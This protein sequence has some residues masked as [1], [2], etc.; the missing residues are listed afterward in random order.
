MQKN[1]AV[2]WFGS[3]RKLA[4]FLG[5]PQSNVSSWKNVPKHHQKTIE[6]HTKG[7]LLAED[8][9]MKTRYMCTIERMY[10]EMLK[11]HSNYLGVPVVEVLR[12][13]IKLYNKKNTF[14]E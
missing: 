3:Q 11:R 10:V 8:A 13:A 12:R 2:E 9:N 4:E 1:E 14:E 7:E 6:A 5:I